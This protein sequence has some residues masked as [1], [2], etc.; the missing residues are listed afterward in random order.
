MNSKLVMVVDDDP[1][2]A[3]SAKRVLGTKFRVD[4]FLSGEDAFDALMQRRY[5]CVVCDVNMIGMSGPDLLRRIQENCPDLARRFMFYT[6]S[7]EPHSL[8]IF[9]V[10]VL[11]KPSSSSVLIARVEELLGVASPGVGS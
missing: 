2:L 11:L 3:R 4:A 6:A 10:P 5:D 9:Q 8:G 1:I 7:I